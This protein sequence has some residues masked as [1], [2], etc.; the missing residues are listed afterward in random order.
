MGKENLITFLKKL[1]K[2]NNKN[3]YWSLVG[4]GG[5]E[6]VQEAQDYLNGQWGSLLH[7]SG[8]VV[9]SDKAVQR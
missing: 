1:I 6:S 4:W 5:K 2:K 7:K 9:E 3:I 8:V